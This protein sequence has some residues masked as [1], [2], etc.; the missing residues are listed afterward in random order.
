VKFAATELAVLG[1]P[2]AVVARL[3]VS[4]PPDA[5]DVPFN[6]PVAGPNPPDRVSVTRT[7][8]ARGTKAPPVAA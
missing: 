1:I 5:I 8:A 4:V 6:G 2:E 7:G 3:N